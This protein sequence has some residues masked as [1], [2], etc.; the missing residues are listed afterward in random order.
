M[1]VPVPSEALLPV[2]LRSVTYAAKDALLFELTALNGTLPLA[3]AGAHIDLHLPSG[4]RQY[5]LVTPF[6]SANSYVVAVKREPNGRGGSLWL[7]DE[8]RV[9]A[10]F[11]IAPP[12]NNF[13]LTETA[14]T[15]LLLAGGI[16]IT[17]I[18]AMFTRL[19]ALGRSVRL[20]YWSRSAEHALFLDHLEDHPDVILHYSSDV[21]R[22]S[23]AAML[24]TISP[25]TEIYCCGP[26]RMLDECAANVQ[27]SGRLHVEHFANIPVAP[28]ED[29]GAF[30][31][32]LARTG[33]DVT[34]APG[35]T[36][37]GA[38]LAAGLEVSYSCEEGVC[39][40]CETKLLEGTPLHRDAVRKPEDHTRLG[41]IMICCSLSHSPQLVLDL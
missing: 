11:Q 23:V 14:K 16:G 5:S 41:T 1:A 25:E 32:R 21:A 37:L 2:R 17:P 28:G 27:H 8:V 7:H 19:Q 13:A 29:V 35:E 36:I 22:T 40:A 26:T 24:A 30:T 31:V 9:G 4:P 15:T 34:I 38:L 10:T 39:G 18:F 6:C 33:R 20:H 12:R 3:E